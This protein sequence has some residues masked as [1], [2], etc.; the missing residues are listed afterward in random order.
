[1]QDAITQAT[2]M[3]TEISFSENGR[4]DAETAE[5]IPGEAT[6][7]KAA[8]RV[9]PTAEGDIGGLPGEKGAGP[10]TRKPEEKELYFIFSTFSHQSVSF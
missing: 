2:I 7:G 8:E 5:G 6:G 9:G 1:M 4:T 3:N 10:P